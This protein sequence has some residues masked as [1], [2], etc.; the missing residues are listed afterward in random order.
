MN[1]TT[2]TLAILLVSTCLWFNPSK[3][4]SQ[5]V[6][7]GDFI[8]DAFY[9]GPNLWNSI[10][11][12]FYVSDPITLTVSTQSLG[13]VGIRGE[14]LLS[15]KFGIG[16]DIMYTGNSIEWTEEDF[17]TPGTYY[18]YKVSINRPRIIPRFNFHFSDND[19]LDLYGVLGIGY[20]GV[21]YSFETNDPD[22]IEESA[23]SLIPI[24]FRLGFGARYF[25]NENMGIC[26]E[27]GLGAALVN[28]GVALKF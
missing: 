25:F 9:G 28:G 12:S 17:F 15:D 5:A 16:L 21:K 11:K 8:V 10:M 13:P 14:Y 20:N 19:N 22:F 2:K 4:K 27:L 6:E 24:A 3:V 1:I 26:A 7:Q 23:K 18:N